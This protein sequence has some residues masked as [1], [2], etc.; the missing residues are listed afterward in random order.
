MLI[1]QRPK[2]QTQSNQ[3]PVISNFIEVND[4]VRRNWTSEL[5]SLS[6]SRREAPYS[7]L[8]TEA[9]RIAKNVL[10]QNFSERLREARTKHPY[11]ILKNLPRDSELLSV[12]TDGKRPSWKQSWISEGVL[13]GIAKTM[14]LEPLSYLQEKEGALIHEISPIPEREKELSNSGRVALDFHTDHAVL[15]RHYRPEFLLLTGLVNPGKAPTLIACIDDALSSLKPEI[16]QVLRQPLFRIE[17]PDSVMVWNGK[18]ILSEW[19]PLLSTASDGTIEF[20][21]NL[22]SVLSKNPEAHKALRLFTR[23]LH[24]TAN[25]IIL[26]SGTA[27]VFDNHRC[28]HARNK[29]TQA[30]WL[31]RMFCRTSLADLRKAKANL[32]PYP[33]MFDMQNLL[34]R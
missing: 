7:Y 14:E 9:P 21:G 1:L 10:P 29:V 33:Y 4:C 15:A 18:K 26:E 24:K 27:I 19:K 32:S 11:I 31:Q 25:K 34:L 30:R 2:T 28:L 12:P 6:M 5:E 20:T 16:E 8:L 22:H 3:A 23:K 13:I 17:L